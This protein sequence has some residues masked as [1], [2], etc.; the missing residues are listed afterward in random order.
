VG[1]VT[2]VTAVAAGQKRRQQPHSQRRVRLPILRAHR[3][4]ALPHRQTPPTVR[5]RHPIDVADAA[6]DT[7]RVARH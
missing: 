5:I 2:G 1:H 4:L 7:D 3:T 6:V